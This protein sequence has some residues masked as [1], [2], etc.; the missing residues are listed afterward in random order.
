MKTIINLVNTIEGIGLDFYSSSDSKKFNAI[1]SD[2]DIDERKVEW[3]IEN[4]SIHYPDP[5]IEKVF[6][7]VSIR[8]KH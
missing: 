8:L 3:D 2:L 7:S 1:K 6:K 4:H 5:K